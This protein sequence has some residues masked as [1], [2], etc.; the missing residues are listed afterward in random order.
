MVCRQ[1]IKGFASGLLY[2][3]ANELFAQVILNAYQHGDVV[4]CHGL[5]SHVASFEIKGRTP[6]DEGWMVSAHALSFQ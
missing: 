1:I 4:W 5:P 3:E 2:Q 6:W